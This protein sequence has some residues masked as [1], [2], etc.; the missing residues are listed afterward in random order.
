MMKNLAVFLLK[1]YKDFSYETK[2][3]LGTISLS[4]ILFDEHGGIK[5]GPKLSNKKGDPFQKMSDYNNWR[6]VFSKIKPI[7]EYQSINNNSQSDIFEIGLILLY[8]AIGD[9]E[10]FANN[11][12]SGALKKKNSNISSEEIKDSM[13]LKSDTNFLLN[14]R[15]KELK[16]FENNVHFESGA[17]CCL[18][19]LFF[20]CCDEKKLKEYLKKSHSSNFFKTF[21]RKNGVL[22]KN[23]LEKKYSA[24]FLDFLCVCLSFDPKNK[25]CYENSLSHKF[26]NNKCSI[27]HE[28][29]LKEITKISSNWNLNK[30][31]YVIKDKIGHI[32][33]SIC[34][35]LEEKEIKRGSFFN[36]KNVEKL[37]YELGYSL[38]I[39]IQTITEMVKAHQI[40]INT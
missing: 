35:V 26:L 11:G 20:D 3:N 38:G 21:C 15:K 29:T 14:D 10:L 22:M 4:Q 8:C 36:E 18:L 24:D 23:I 2:T 32:L 5:I 16:T 17:S 9:I 1:S 19:H 30:S 31:S 27:N 37:A 7:S 39:S 6:A 12:G 40:N 13:F 33:Q 25:Q 28:I 34:I